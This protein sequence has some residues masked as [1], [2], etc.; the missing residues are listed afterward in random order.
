MI[1]IAMIFAGVIII[2]L[3]AC[4]P[5]HLST[6]LSLSKTS[7]DKVPTN[8]NKQSSIR[9][10]VQDDSDYAITTRSIKASFESIGLSIVSENNLNEEFST[11]FE[12]LDY[13]AYYLSFFMN[14]NLSYKLIRK[15]PKFG[16][17]TPLSMSIWVDKNNNMHI[18]T[19][20]LSSMAKIADIPKDDKD[21]LAYSHLIN[22]ALYTTMPKGEF[23]EL[24]DAQNDS[25]KLFI[26]EYKSVLKETVPVVESELESE[27]DIAGFFIP[28]YIDLK[29][30]LFVRHDYDKYD[31]FHSY[32]ICDLSA[33]YNEAKQNPQMG[34]WSPC[35]FYIYKSKKS[36]NV[37]M[38][39]VPVSMFTS[40]SKALTKSQ[41]ILDNT[42][43]QILE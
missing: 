33:L 21:L 25:H 40:K 18:A 39:Y 23:K 11:H 24:P 42:L 4:T 35:S 34:A 12:A 6:P 22:K 8:P 32:S 30:S 13:K 19:L 26:K 36:Q 38:G 2:S 41:G 1:N 9:I 10:Y 3:T 43:T 5:S 29:E 14:H 17:L 16:L 15:Y 31:Y 7:K 27:L 37:V 20:S 28:H